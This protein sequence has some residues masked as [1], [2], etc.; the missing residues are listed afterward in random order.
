MQHHLEYLLLLVN[1]FMLRINEY[2]H[3]KKSLNNE[4][5]IIHGTGSREQNL[6][7]LEIF[8]KL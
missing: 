2:I 8:C 4:D 7:M 3:R 5:L 6:H 1:T